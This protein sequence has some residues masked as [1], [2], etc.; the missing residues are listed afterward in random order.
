MNEIINWERVNEKSKEFRT[1]KPTRWAFIEDFFEEDFYEKLYETYPKYDNS[2][3][4]MDSY[5]KV[6]YRKFWGREND[7]QIVEQEED[8]NYS[9]EWNMFVKYLHS[10]GFIEKIRDFSGVEVT[11][12][13]HFQFALIKKNGFQLPHIHNVGPNTL[14]F[15]IYFSKNWNKG[16]P[17]GTYITPEENESKL[18]FE[19]YNLNNSAMIFHDGPY[20]G[21]G[22]R[23]VEKDV[24]RRAIQI[25]LEEYSETGWSGDKKDEEKI[26]L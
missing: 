23:K 5:D 11:K 22:V 7:E 4:K 16:D 17:G 24:E 8:Q 12:L 26:E 20:A 10:D 1:K 6:S 25:Y 15:M 2:W 13:K 14:I 3:K 19:P 21:H 18:I 9:K